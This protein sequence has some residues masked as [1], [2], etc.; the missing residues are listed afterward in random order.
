MP[1]TLNDDKM[2]IFKII[3][4]DP[5]IKSLGF[6]ADKIYRFRNSWD[7]VTDETKQIFIFNMQPENTRS[8]IFK[9]LVYQIDITVPFA[10]YNKADLASE[11]IM[12][13]LDGRQITD[14]FHTLRLYSPPMVLT[15]PSNFYS[16]GIR[17]GCAETVFNKIKK[18]K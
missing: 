10:E 15:A 8:A 4:E 7:L 17:F 1:I 16:I 9:K 3:S 12:A 11:Q 18:I 5:Y 14:T 2:E 6:T 13:L